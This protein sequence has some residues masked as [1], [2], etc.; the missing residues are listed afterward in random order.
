M[1]V[2]ASV[3]KSHEQIMKIEVAQLFPTESGHHE[4]IRLTPSLSLSDT[5]PYWWVLH[6]TP[7]KWDWTLNSQNLRGVYSQVSTRQHIIFVCLFLYTLFL[8]YIVDSIKIKP[9]IHFS[10]ICPRTIA[11]PGASIYREFSMAVLSPELPYKPIIRI[12]TL[13][14]YRCL[15]LPNFRRRQ[16]TNNTFVHDSSHAWARCCL[17]RHCMVYWCKA[18]FVCNERILNTAFGCLSIVLIAVLK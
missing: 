16:D 2:C 14:D 4:D 1:F 17:H 13:L 5:L 15:M 7:N 6:T 12:P 9:R 8:K 10:Y 11:V 18:P 3:Y